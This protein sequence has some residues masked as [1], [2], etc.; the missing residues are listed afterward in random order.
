MTVVKDTEKIRDDANLLTYYPEMMDDREINLRMLLYSVLKQWRRILAAAVI[1]GI[2][3]CG[4][5]GIKGYRA[6][7]EAQNNPSSVSAIEKKIEEADNSINMIQSSIDDTENRIRQAE[8]YFYS[9]SEYFSI[10]PY[11][12]YTVTV[13]Y[14]IKPTSDNLAEGVYQNIT[15]QLIE[16]YT[17]EALNAVEKNEETLG[18]ETGVGSKYCLVDSGTENNML[19]TLRAYGSKE[20]TAAAVSEIIKQSVNDKHNEFNERI[21][22]H[23]LTLVSE[24]S[25]VY[26]N[27][28][29]EGNQL[30]YSNVLTLLRNQL[31]K[32][33]SQLDTLISERNNLA[34][35]IPAKS[36]I[37]KKC[38]KNSL[39]GFIAGL[40]LMAVY[41]L[42][43][44]VLSGTLQDPDDIR[45][46]CSGTVIDVVP[47]K[48][49][50]NDCFIDKLIARL[51]PGRFSESTEN[52]MRYLAGKLFVYLKDCDKAAFVSTAGKDTC[53][54]LGKALKKYLPNMDIITSGDPLSDLSA[55]EAISSTP[56][57]VIEKRGES[58]I[59][60]I[61]TEIEMLS[62][63]KADCRGFI[64]L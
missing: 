55:I 9:D 34:G 39:V 33:Q 58:K 23:T 47:A 60:N 21:E 26:Y 11:K 16:A 61:V 30:N 43:N 1:L 41:Y 64:V 40:F 35:S 54:Q 59:D 24:E 45:A 62:G 53:E 52:D 57:V 18:V 51:Y 44:F 20:E 15:E 14:S 36:N 13:T 12:T 3:L 42:V 22:P 32:S 31:E 6:M 50:K 4:Y 48:P 49:D 10:D 37:I 17:I 7:R 29:I 27:N 8:S 38:V 2:I 28:D 63:T 46:I 5:A 19:L 25:G 56:L